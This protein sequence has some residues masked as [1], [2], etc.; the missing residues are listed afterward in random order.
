M[1]V[2]FYDPFAH[3]RGETSGLAD[4]AELP[5]AKRRQHRKPPAENQQRARR[6]V[7]EDLQELLSKQK[8]PK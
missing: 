6:E 7:I 4:P 2:D 3:D 5:P 1:R 8:D